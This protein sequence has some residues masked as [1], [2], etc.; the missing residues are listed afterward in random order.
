MRRLELML[1]CFTFGVIAGFLLGRRLFEGY[2]RRL[3]YD[4]IVCA[5]D[6]ADDEQDTGEYAA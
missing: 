4:V 6:D 1:D 3:E 5:D 2:V